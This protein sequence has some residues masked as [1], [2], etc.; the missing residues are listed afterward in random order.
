MKPTS[1]TFVSF[2]ILIL[3]SSLNAFSGVQEDLVTACLQG[4]KAAAEKAIAGGA[5]VNKLDANGNTPICSSYFSPEIT[6]LLID[7]GADANGGNYVALV[8][9][10]NN[11]SVE[12]LKI[13]LAAGA[14]PNKGAKV[15]PNTA[16][17]QNLIDA[18]K[19]KGKK[20]NKVIIEAW[21]AAVANMKPTT[22]YALQVTIQQTNCVPCL[23]MLYK[24]GAKE[25]IAYSD[26]NAFHSLAVFSMTREERKTAFTA[27]KAG[28]ESYGL[29][30]PDWYGNLPDDKNGTPE[31]MMNVIL[32]NGADINKKRA[33]GHTPLLVAMAVHKPEISKAL[34]KAGANAKDPCIIKGVKKD[35][36]AYPIC[37][38]AEFMDVES[39]TMILDQGADIN[40]STE[41]ITLS[42]T[43]K[44]K[45]AVNWGGDGYTPLIISI[46][47]DQLDVA[48]YLLSQDANIKIGSNG[49]SILKTKYEDLNCLVTIKNKTPIYWA[50]ERDD[51]EFVEMIGKKMEWKFNPD[52]TIKQYDPGNKVDMGAYELKCASFKSKQSPSSYASQIGNKEASKLLSSKGL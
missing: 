35:L 4:D 24:A 10:S 27:G 22:I 39:M 2:G 13:L 19:A 31:D 12:V 7:K 1:K 21:E 17:L 38:A 34:L 42:M 43:A 11:Y 37:K 6:Q 48:R 18:E 32:A 33:D 5:D 40:V 36:T 23:E 50:V 44:Y 28:M 41:T 25:D 20:A 45:G 9:A 46:M 47:F 3:L 15:I 26:G 52:F 14:D 49:V 29:N 16:P 30:V 51:L 8:S